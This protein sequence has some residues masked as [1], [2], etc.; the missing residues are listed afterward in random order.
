MNGL[1]NFR[2]LG[3][4]PVAGGGTTAHG[5]LFRSDSLSYATDEDAAHLRDTLG[6]RTVVDLRDPREVEEFGRGPLGADPAVAYVSLPCDDVPV[7]SS[8]R[9]EFYASVL[10]THGDR[11]AGLVRRV[12]ADVPLLVHCHIGCDRTGIVSA[13]LLSLAGVS[14]ADVC[15]DYARSH[16]ASPI[17]QQRSEDRRRA[18]GL[19]VMDQSYYDAW[20]PRPEI[21]ADTLA[22]VAIRFGGMPG[23]AARFG[24]TDADLAT[25]RG[26]LVVG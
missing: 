17:V 13:M 11:L 8:V 25:L 9:H 26:V 5:V 18:L 19:P 1:A 16:R 4:L 2:D 14:G 15:A 3:G 20:E 23:W 12:A 22:I 24:L 10:E 6:V 21:M 7:S